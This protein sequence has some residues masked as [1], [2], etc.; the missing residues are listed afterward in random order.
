M[1]SP[2][3]KCYAEELTLRQVATLRWTDETGYPLIS[4]DA[5]EGAYRHAGVYMDTLARELEITYDWEDGDWVPQSHS[6]LISRI[7]QDGKPH[8]QE[9]RHYYPVT[10]WIIGLAVEFA[11]EFDVV[12]VDKGKP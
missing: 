1:T 9:F 7:R 8:G 2:T 4:K 11:P 10:D 12:L 5:P 6:L 3:P